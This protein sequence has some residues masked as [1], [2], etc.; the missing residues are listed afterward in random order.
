MAN[1]L[2]MDE[3][4]DQMPKL[5]DDEA[6]TFADPNAAPLPPAPTPQ[7]PNVQNADY[8]LLAGMDP[9]KV[10]AKQLL[11]AQIKQAGMDR[12]SAQDQGLR[13]SEIKKMEAKQLLYNRLADS[14]MGLTNAFIDPKYQMKND[15]TKEIAGQI[16]KDQAARNALRQQLLAKS[17][18]GVGGALGGLVKLQGMDAQNKYRQDQAAQHQKDLA[19]TEAGKDRRAQVMAGL[20]RDPVETKLATDAAMKAVEQAA[21][22]SERLAK[23]PTTDKQR[24][25]SNAMGLKALE[26]MKNAYASGQSRYKMIGDN[27]FTKNLRMFE[28]AIGRM[29]SGGAISTDEGTRFK[30]MARSFGDNPAIAKQKLDDLYAEMS[31][32]MQT[33]NLSPA[34]IKEIVDRRRSPAG[35]ESSSGTAMAAAPKA[36]QHDK[37]LDWYNDPKNAQ[38][39]RREDIGKKLK[40]EGKL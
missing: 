3:E 36:P 19:A 33:Y 27:T 10:D 7:D 15:A 6:E 16:G 1:Y 34:D 30:D 2:G 20:R 37:A 35:E 21:P 26:D 39:P 22:L 25:D 4:E 23:L 40:A 9:N 14:A 5:P 29:Q 12:K 31:A 28:E 38:D 18:A 13:D 17:Q 32:R 24:I 8:G 11:I